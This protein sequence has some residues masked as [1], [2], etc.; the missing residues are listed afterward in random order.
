MYIYIG[1]V[2]TM[3]RYIWKLRF[4]SIR[5]LAFSAQVE[6]G[7]AVFKEVEAM[8]DEVAEVAGWSTGSGAVGGMMIIDIGGGALL[9]EKPL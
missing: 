5:F 4:G 2:E 6:Q 8:P 3:Y 1:Y 7:E 9:S